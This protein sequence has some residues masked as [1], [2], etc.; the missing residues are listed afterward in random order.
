MTPAQFWQIEMNNRQDRA[1]RQQ[2]TLSNA[3]AN[4]GDAYAKSQERTAKLEGIQATGSA[5]QAILPQYGQEGMALGKTLE[6]ELGKAG[7]NPDKIAGTMMAF[8]PAVE[9]LRSRFNENAR[10]EGYKDLSDYKA[11][12]GADT[13]SSPRLNADYFRSMVVEAKAAGFSDDAIKSKI[14]QKYGDYAV[15]FV[16]P[17]QNQGIWMGQ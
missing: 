1:A 5:M 10:I 15:R 12:L 16:Y 14:Q 17:P 13:T 11:S 9:N 3:L 6:T 7:N 8:M 2:E 4:L